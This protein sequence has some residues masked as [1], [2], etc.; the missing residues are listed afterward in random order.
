MQRMQRYP[1]V[2]LLQDTTTLNYTVQK[3]RQDI[4]PINRENH[5]GLL[6][7]PTLA[8]TPERLCLGVVDNYYW[9]RK[10][11]KHRTPH[12]K[13]RDNHRTPLKEKE[14]HRWLKG[15]QI[16]NRVA[17]QLP[18]TMVVSVADREADIYDLYHEAQNN[19]PYK[20][21]AYWLIRASANTLPT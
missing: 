7:Y 9:A 1:V 5:R 19:N 16:A 4:G 21:A 20:T 17:A 2:L 10:T 12:E 6:F 15:Y 8:V 11:I 18:K 14:S 3:Q 13:S